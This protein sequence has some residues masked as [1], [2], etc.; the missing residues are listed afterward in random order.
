MTDHSHDRH[1]IRDIQQETVITA[2]GRTLTAAAV[3]AALIG[4][5]AACG[6][7]ENLTAGQKVDRAFD[8]LGRERSLALELDVDA[9]AARVRS[10]AAEADP[11]AELPLEVARLISDAR[12]SIAVRSTKPLEQSGDDDIAGVAVTVDT[13][14]GALIEYRQVGD[15]LYYRVDAEALK[16]LTGAPLPSA[17]DLPPEAD[18]ARKALQG[19]WIKIDRKKLDETKAGMKEMGGA[20]APQPSLDAKAQKKLVKALRTVIAR[21]VTF[22]SRDGEGDTEHITAT[23]PLRTLLTSLFGQ[24]RPLAGD[25]PPG[26]AELPTDEDLKDA[27]NRKVGADFTLTGGGLTAVSIDLAELSERPSKGGKLPLVLRIDEAGRITAPAGATELDLEQM[28]P[29]LLGPGPAGEDPF[30]GE[31]P[32]AEE[33]LVP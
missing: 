18:A 16:D 19:E 33:G 27:P 8:R 4:G 30:P 28:M 29:G 3:A 13:P 32:L 26:L 20:P 10:L 2:I 23:A 11:D 25:L 24:I 17:D 5:A 21:E 12:I 1:D 9:T 14:E 7:V 22:T 31:D 6:T 15:H